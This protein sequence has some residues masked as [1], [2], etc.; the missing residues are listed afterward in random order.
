MG[1]CSPA[2]PGSSPPTPAAC[3]G[4]ARSPS[5]TGAAAAGRPVDP[6]ELRAVPSR[7]PRPPSIAA[8]LDAG[9]DIGNDG[10]QARESFFTYVQHRMTGF[11]GTSQRPIMRDLA[12][13]PRLHRA[14]RARAPS[15]RQ[16][17]LLTAP[18]AIAEVTYRR[19]A[20]RSRPS[21]RLVA[22]APFAETFM[23][24]ASP[25]IVPPRWRTASTPSTDDYVAR[26]RGGARAPSTAPSSTG[27]CCCRSTRPTSPSSATP[28]SPSGR[29]AT[30]STGWSSSSRPSTP[31]STASTRPR[32]PA[33]LLGQLRGPP[34]PRRRPR[35]R[36]SRCSTRPTS[37]R[38]VLSMA[39]ARHAHEYRCFERLPLPDG[40]VLVA[41]VIDTTSNY[42]EHPEV[43]ADRLERVAVAGRR[44]DARHRRHRLRLRHVGRASATSPRRSCGRS[45]APSATAPTWPR[46]ACCEHPARLVGAGHGRRAAR[47][48]ARGPRLRRRRGARRQSGSHRALVR[49]RGARRRRRRAQRR[50]R[51]RRGGRP[52]RARRRAAGQRARP[53]GGRGRAHREPRRD[54]PGRRG[55]AGRGRRRR[56]RRRGVGLPVVGGAGRGRAGVGR[57]Q[58]RV[59]V[60]LDGGPDAERHAHPGAVRRRRAAPGRWGTAR[61]SSGTTNRDEGAYLGFFGKASD[62]MVDLQPIS[63]LH[64]SEVRALATRLGVPAE[65]VEAAPRATCGTAAPMPR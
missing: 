57:R 37:A 5:S 27:A 15:A 48:G 22:D 8:Q 33:R 34:H 54:E 20:P 29:W 10:E 28:C 7:P 58:R 31:P 64:K 56:A 44:P 26:G 11:G 61:S 25:G 51:L 12:R 42:V 47:P 40:M 3:P 38:L 59:P 39:N 46:P 62:G 43:V 6:D 9:I 18:A 60:G 30:S 4:R 52:A 45:C 49:R 53:G 23:T 55:A 36:S 13:P 65:I 24:A 50:R 63:D 32:A 21:A 14:G 19:H 16:V 41:G 35:R 1:A 17:N 2:S